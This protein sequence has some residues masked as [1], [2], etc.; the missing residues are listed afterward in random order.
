MA[1]PPDPNNAEQMAP[2]KDISKDAAAL[3]ASQLGELDPMD[4]VDEC[5]RKW[6]VQNVYN[7]ILSRDTE[8]F[9]YLHLRLAVLARDLKALVPGK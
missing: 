4:P 5:I 1:K 9:N 7:S 3:G 6:E 8:A 2:V